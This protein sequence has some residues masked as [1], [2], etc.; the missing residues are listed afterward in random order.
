MLSTNFLNSLHYCLR[1]RALAQRKIEFVVNMQ[2]YE[3]VYKN[4]D[5][6]D[7]QLDRQINTNIKQLNKQRQTDRSGAK[8]K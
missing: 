6:G 4:T 2:I 7:G 8:K 1:R 3:R 5:R